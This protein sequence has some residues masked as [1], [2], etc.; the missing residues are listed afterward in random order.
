MSKKP[1]QHHVV[2]NGE[3]GWDV[4]RDGAKRISYHSHNKQDAIDRARVISK[5]QNTELYIHGKNGAIQKRDSHGQDPCP[6]KDANK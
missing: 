3:N 1:R 6:P 2:P 4:K 5:N